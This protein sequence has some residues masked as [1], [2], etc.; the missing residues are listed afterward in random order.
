MTVVAIELVA[1]AQGRAVCTV[2]A[3]PWP[4]AAAYVVLALAAVVSAGAAFGAVVAVVAVA[5]WH[6][7]QQ[8]ATALLQQL[9]RLLA[10][11]D[12]SNLLSLCPWMGQRLLQEPRLLVGS[13]PAE[14]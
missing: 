14:S 5:A 3:S 7:G 6:T 8:V 10:A 12:V 11:S 1:A 2:A 4:A 13:V 9:P